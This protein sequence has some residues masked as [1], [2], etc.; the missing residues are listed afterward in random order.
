MFI[1]KKFNTKNTKLTLL[2]HYFDYNYS[3]NKNNIKTIFS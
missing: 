3:I 2:I 1:I